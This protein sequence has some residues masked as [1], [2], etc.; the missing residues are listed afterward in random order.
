MQVLVMLMT[1]L[2]IVLSNTV[3]FHF[4]QKTDFC[5]SCILGKAHQLPFSDSHTVY[6][7]PLQLI[8]INIWGPSPTTSSNGSYYYIG[9]LDAYTKYTWFYLL[10]RKSQATPIFKSFKTFVEKQ[11]GYQL[12]AIQTNNAKEFLCI[13]SYLVEH[14]I[15]HRLTC[16]Y[17]SKTV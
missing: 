14:G 12:K 2:F 9:F 3:N 6:T 16:P 11:T 7:T 17:T 5:D 10:Q 4:L 8:Y 1:L 15:H 13:K